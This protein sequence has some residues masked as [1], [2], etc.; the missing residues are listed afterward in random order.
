M[1]TAKAQPQPLLLNKPSTSHSMDYGDD[2]GFT[3]VKNFLVLQED[4]IQVPTTPSKSSVREDICLNLFPQL[5]SPE[6]NHFTFDCS[7][8]S[9]DFEQFTFHC[10]ALALEMVCIV[11]SSPIDNFLLHEDPD[12]LGLEATLKHD[13]SQ[14]PKDQF[15]AT[16]KPCTSVRKLIFSLVC[17]HAKYMFHKTLLHLP[18]TSTRMALSTLA[19]HGVL[20]YNF[21]PFRSASFNIRVLHFSY[22]FDFI[23]YLIFALRWQDPP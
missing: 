4:H 23:S 3:F 21:F 18:L 8:L 17:S 12:F 10:P 20:R 2:A 6:F 14:L 19:F 5:F 13:E 15:S 11:D 1:Y 16:F 9:P 7:S 22:M